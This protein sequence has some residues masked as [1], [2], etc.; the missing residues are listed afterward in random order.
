MKLL[1]TFVYK[2]LCGHVFSFPLG[3]SSTFFCCYLYFPKGYN[4]PIYL[5]AYFPCSHNQ[6]SPKSCDR[7]S[8]YGG[9]FLLSPSLMSPLEPSL[10]LSHL[11]AVQ[12]CYPALTRDDLWP[13]PWGPCWNPCSIVLFSLPCINGAHPPV[14]SWESTLE[15]I[16]GHL[17]CLK[18]SLFYPLFNLIVW[19]SLEF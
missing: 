17:A 10:F 6:F 9:Q 8:Q 12:V 16:W 1:W 14:A 18:I 5:L 2:L 15:V 3:R 19:L 4:S 13:S 11:M 7:N